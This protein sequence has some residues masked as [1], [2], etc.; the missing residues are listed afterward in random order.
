M[1]MSLPTI[2]EETLKV[3]ES[4][5]WLTKNHGKPHPAG[6]YKPANLKRLWNDLRTG[7]A[8]GMVCHSS[9]PK[10]IDYGSTSKVKD[11]CKP[12]ECAGALLMVAKH[13]NEVS[14]AS[15]AGDKKLA[16]YKAKHRF[17]LTRDGIRNW[18][19][20]YVFGRFRN[21]EDRSTDV[22]L[23]WESQTPESK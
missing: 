13:L 15:E 6:W 17:P 19:G 4:C 7:R 8:P 9:D 12:R 20:E 11:T 5:P 2:R 10:S 14:A 1:S 23:P 18:I 16:T 22:S 3:C 21:I